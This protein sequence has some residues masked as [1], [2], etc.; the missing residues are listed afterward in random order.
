MKI[1]RKKVAIFT[2][3]HKNDKLCL[4]LRKKVTIYELQL[5]SIN[6]C[7]NIINIIQAC[8]NY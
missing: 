4:G 2:A 8:T 3:P 7:N 6:I 1:K 5:I